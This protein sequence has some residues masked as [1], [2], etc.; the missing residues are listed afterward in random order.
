M[1]KNCMRICSKDLKQEQVG[2]VKNEEQKIQVG[3]LK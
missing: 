2:G 3:P 1:E